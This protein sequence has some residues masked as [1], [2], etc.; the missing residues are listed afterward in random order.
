MPTGRVAVQWPPECRLLVGAIGALF[1]AATMLAA[2]AAGAGNRDRETPPQ[3]YPQFEPLPPA[4]SAATIRLPPGYRVDVVAAEPMI[5][6]PVWVA[7]D[8]DGAMYVAEM[9]SYMQ[10]VHGTGTKTIRNG[11]I[12]RLV[13]LDGDGI[14]DRATVF[15]DHLLL[16]RMILALDERIL[17]QET[18][19]SNLVALRDTDGDGVADERKVLHQGETLIISVEHQDS[20]LTWAL[21][22]WIYT[23][24]GGKRFRYTRGRWESE[25]V[26]EMLSNQWGMGMDDTGMLYFSTNHVPGR[27]FN[28]HWYYWN[29]I[30]ERREWRR[31]G[32]PTIGPETDDEFQLTFRAQPIGNRAD[33]PRARW[34]SACGISIFR[35]DALPPDFQGNLL[36]AEP[37]GHA[38]RRAVV[39][40]D[41]Y[42]RRVVHNP[43]QDQK[44]E[45]FMAE[46]FYSRPVS[47]HTGPDG[48]LY[49]VDMYRGIIQDAFWVS[50][51]FADRITGM[52]VDRV[53]N[54]GRIYR[55]SHE[56]RSP[57]P[58]PRLLE[59]DPA[60]L[61]PHL[62]HPN[63]WWRDTAQRL[64]ILRGDRSVL[65]ALRALVRGHGN[66]LARLHALW[67][68]EGFDALAPDLLAEK[69]RDA[70]YRLR[71]AA[72]RLHEPTL[73]GPGGAEAIRTLA[74][75][76]DD[77]DPEVR[78]QLMLSLGWSNAP[79]AL[80]II[81]ARAT[82]EPENP[83]IA[84]AALTALHGREELPLARQVG[85]G[86]LFA[87]ISDPI[88][89][90]AAAELWRSGI[91]TWREAPPVRPAP[92]AAEAKR[93]EEG[94]RIFG[95]HCALC[96]GI[97][98]KGVSVD[99]AP[100]LGPPLAGSARV[101]GRKEGL[102]RILLH[103][104]TSPGGSTQFDSGLMAPLG[105]ALP[106]ADLA[107]LLSYIRQAWTNDAPAL[108]AADVAATRA[109][110]TGRA[111]PW[112]FAELAALQ[113]PLLQDR[114]GWVAT[115][116]GHQP[117][118][119]IDGV[120]DASQEHAWHGAQN[121]GVWLA[122][123]LGR[124]HRVNQVTMLA[125]QPQWSPKSYAVDT[126]LD[127]RDWSPA[128]VRADGT[129]LRTVATF[130]PT[131]ARHLRITQTGNRIERWVVSELE[132]YGVAMPTD[133]R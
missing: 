125:P 70:D 44:A 104:F 9:N 132:I 100:A 74:P 4:E 3:S 12:K 40:R 82:A 39:V 57:G 5:R 26:L 99:G 17:I 79:K 15:A 8:G 97:D 108:L 126:S 35:G 96:H 112:T 67:T 48:C 111:D 69:L 46:D 90:K 51:S 22:N 10:D 92:S 101:L 58:A 129:G 24:Q 21:D 85:D 124:P 64:L 103:G 84:L 113:D 73:R 25:Q 43:Y 88:E 19:N 63:G 127:G 120:V 128:V 133:T 122:V 71:A 33:K 2:P 49:I 106:D 61:V 116:S 107:A 130:E 66:P 87:S 123:D 86:S 27:N 98:G 41:D 16:P 109:R 94:A 110:T 95:Q 6:E 117:Q 20:A 114:S 119:A 77:P 29:L 52:G 47:T 59:A 14:M 68:L 54:R 42:G 72:V 50:P 31:F 36:V 56:S 1:A 115:G 11:R 93:I 81:Q 80:E 78:R 118:N 91:E 55:I 28:Q 121:P 53:K 7:W 60:D 23:A 13:D 30:G 62:A 38:V 32:L 18:D 65:P 89:R 76:A 83:I 37:C 45:F 102:I 34:T 131:A 75:L 105:T